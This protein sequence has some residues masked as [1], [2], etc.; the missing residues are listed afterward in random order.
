M[1]R[2][3][4]FLL[5]RL[6]HFESCLDL[7][8]LAASACSGVVEDSVSL[9]GLYQTRPK[10]PDP[11]TKKKASEGEEYGNDVDAIPKLSAFGGS[12]SVGVTNIC[13]TSDSMAIIGVTS[14]S[15]GL[16]AQNCFPT[17]GGGGVNGKKKNINNKK[18]WVLQVSST[19]DTTSC[20][21]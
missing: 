18:I 11:V 12:A 2:C 15:P 20:T 21:M 7:P 10:K 5:R 9:Y 1:V 19:R 16:D 6:A 3:H 8:V 4:L 17:L 13:C 14:P